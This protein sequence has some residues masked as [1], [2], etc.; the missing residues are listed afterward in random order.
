MKSKNLT[1]KATLAGSLLVVTALII[2]R[3]SGSIPTALKGV[4]DKEWIDTRFPEK[5]DT[6]DS[7][8]QVMPFGYTLGPWP[9]EFHQEPILTKVNYIK[10][11][12][13]KFIQS[14][15]QLW[16]PVEVELTL[17]GPKTIS[18]DLH[19]QDWKECFESTWG[20]RSARQKLLD[21]V[22]AGKEGGKL[23]TATWF[24]HQEADGPR[25]V[26]LLWKFP[27]YRI[28]DY[29]LLTENGIAQAFEL[30]TVNTNWGN[31]ARN[32][33]V[34]TL[35]SLRVRE[36]L[37]NSRE[38]IQNRIRTVNL[39][40]IRTLSDPKKKLL[41]LIET[42]NWLFSLLSVDPSQVTPFF[43]LAGVSHLLALELIRSKSPVF[44]NQ[45]SWIL[46]AKPNLD[47]LLKFSKDFNE[48]TIPKQI[49]ALI[50]DVLL[51]QQKSTSTRK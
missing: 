33:L 5:I 40:Q 30:K 34:Q 26:H 31:D 35:G 14:I 24:D 25:G 49:E 43:H 9:T 38:W 15:T 36:D 41:K 2:D 16:M 46:S 45:E 39:D 20:C 10:G 42:Q 44:E 27:Q 32:L 28:D 23:E 29:I 4:L 1:L 13:K 11:P 50:Q 19:I 21:Y 37:K 3:Y 12:P 17:M 18:S 51:E 8:W 7:T 6:E 22:I 47:A 48:D